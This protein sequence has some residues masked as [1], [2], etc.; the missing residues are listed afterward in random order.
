MSVGG[1]AA[2]GFTRDDVLLASAGPPICDAPTVLL[3]RL[4][5]VA[6]WVIEA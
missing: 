1:P 4:W 5:L 2:D 6:V 3:D